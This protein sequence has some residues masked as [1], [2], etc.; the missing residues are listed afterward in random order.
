VIT[1]QETKIRF[2]FIKEI[3]TANDAYEIFYFDEKMNQNLI[4]TIIRNC[5]IDF[6]SDERKITFQQKLKVD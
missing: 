6:N 4:E 3:K 1:N 5:R 2:N